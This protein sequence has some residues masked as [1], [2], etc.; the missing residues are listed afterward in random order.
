MVTIVNQKS[1]HSLKE[2][3][4][5]SIIRMNVCTKGDKKQSNFLPEYGDTKNVDK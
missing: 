2:R 4:G 3:R 1:A 5:G